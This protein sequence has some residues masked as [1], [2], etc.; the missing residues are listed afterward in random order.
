MVDTRKLACYKKNLIFDHVVFYHHFYFVL[1]LWGVGDKKAITITYCY[2][3]HIYFN[4]KHTS[5]SSN[6]PDQVTQGNNTGVVQTGAMQDDFLLQ[7]IQV[8]IV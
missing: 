3:D 2:S 6:W 5:L 4:L 7:M 8:N 1:F